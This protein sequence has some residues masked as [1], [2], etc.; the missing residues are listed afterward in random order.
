MKDALQSSRVPRRQKLDRVSESSDHRLTPN[1]Y[2][3]R[4]VPVLRTLTRTESELKQGTR[5]VVL[6]WNG[7]CG[8]NLQKIFAVNGAFCA[9]VCKTVRPMI[10]DRCLPVL[11]VTLVYCG[12]T[13]GRIKMKLGKHI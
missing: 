5:L 3:L 11:S 12:Q 4:L 9:T 1:G 2:A 6:Q 8:A 13:V 10:S 7:V